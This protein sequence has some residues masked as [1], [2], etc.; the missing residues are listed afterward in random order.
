MSISSVPCA[1]VP[2]EPLATISFI[3][4]FI[5]SFNASCIPCNMIYNPIPPEST[6]LAF[7]RAG[8]R[9]GVLSSITFASLT[10]SFK[11][12]TISVLSLFIAPPSTKALANSALSTLVLPSNPLEI[13]LSIW[14]KITPEFPLAPIKAPLANFLEV[15]PIDSE[16]KFSISLTAALN[17]IDIFVPVSPSGTGNTFKAL[18]KSLSSNNLLL[19]LTTIL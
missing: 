1:F 16:F 9:S 10:T 14:D 19:A 11:S 6:T 18:T 7:L 3:S 5:S 17:V 4:A 13:P 12:S 15:S 2:V 8:K